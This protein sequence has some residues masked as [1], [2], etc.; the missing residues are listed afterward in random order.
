[1]VLAWGQEI[2]VTA[3]H[4]EVL[5]RIGLHGSGVCANHVRDEGDLGVRHAVV[6]HVPMHPAKKNTKLLNSRKLGISYTHH[7]A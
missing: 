6:M 1:M 7:L 4:E 5:V 2:E 3:N